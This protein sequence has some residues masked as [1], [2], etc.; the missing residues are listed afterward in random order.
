M[1]TPTY[2]SSLHPEHRA[3]AVGFVPFSPIFG[4]ESDQRTGAGS[5]VFSIHSPWEWKEHLGLMTQHGCGGIVWLRVL[6]L[7][8]PQGLVFCLDAQVSLVFHCVAWCPG[9]KN[10]QHMGREWEEKMSMICK[11]NIST[12]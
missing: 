4:Q 9:I 2:L 11:G 3:E 6:P 7:P 5:S 12:S 10:T 1:L 8:L